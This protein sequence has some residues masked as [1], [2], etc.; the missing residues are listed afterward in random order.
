MVACS[1]EMRPVLMSGNEAIARG[2]YEAGVTV[3]TGYPGTPSTEII[4]TLATYDEISVQWSANEKVAMEVAIGASLAGARVLV[5]Q[6]HVGLNVA[7]DPLMTFCYLPTLGGMVI[8]SADDPGMHSSQNEQD[9]RHYGRMARLPVLMPSDSQEAKTFTEEACELSERFQAPVILRSTTRLSHGRST[10]LLGTRKSPPQPGFARRPQDLVMV[11]ANAR[12]RH[13]AVEQ[14][15]DELRR[16]AEETSLNRI[17]W[18][19]RSIGFITGGVAY[20]YV[21]EAFPEASVFKL[22]LAYP[23]PAQQI[24]RFAEEVEQLFVVEE[25][26]PFWE[27]I[28]LAQ[29]VKVIGQGIA[30]PA[31][32]PRTGELSVEKV[33]TAVNRFLKGEPVYVTVPAGASLLMENGAAGNE[34]EEPGTAAPHISAEGRRE[35]EHSKTQELPQRP[36]I[37]CPG[38]PHRGVFYVLAKRRL[39]TIGDIGCYALGSAPPFNSMDVSTCMGASVGHAFGLEKA[40]GAEFARKSI[41]VIGDS[42]FI[43]SGI[44][45]LIDV[46]HNRGTI[47]V[48]ILDNL[49][50]AMTGHQGN[51]ASGLDG[52]GRQAP[53]VCLED[54]CKACGVR[55]VRT[56]DA[57]DLRGV[58]E[59]IMAAVAK[60]EP[61]VVIARRACALLPGTRRPPVEF[62]A[63]NCKECGACFRLGCPALEKSGQQPK[64]REETC[65]GCGVCVQLCR[66]GALVAR[67]VN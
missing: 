58:E 52:R 20:Q 24:R 5:A 42:T 41:A 39:I 22:G 33:Y 3:A 16:F 2:A 45:P 17:E 47:T 46:V 63:E 40:L 10:V 27:E 13:L 29:G 11:P 34:S 14:R 48:V 50:T 32:L 55:D 43:H 66:H 37:M 38:C 36:P 62:I 7:A 59:A 64:L 44:S 56:V 21:K 53:R 54:L 18:G 57:Y 25:G 6:K 1:G 15:L 28:I 23:L 31:V 9:N 67:E 30:G 60:E 65:V 49:T 61:S 26:D 51:P 8:V 12:R 35:M 19:S 4:E